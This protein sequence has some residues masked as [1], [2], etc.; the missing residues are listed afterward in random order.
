[1]NLSVIFALFVDSNIRRDWRCVVSAM[2]IFIF[3]K[4][5]VFRALFNA[6]CGSSKKKKQFQCVCSYTHYIIRITYDKPWTVSS[7]FRELVSVVHGECISS[8]Y[9][10]RRSSFWH[11]F[12]TLSMRYLLS[13]RPNLHSFE[14]IKLISSLLTLLFGW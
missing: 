8:H 1:M 11:N 9:G 10:L 14:F 5:V 3:K 6:N 7:T 4:R 13:M 12:K 2:T